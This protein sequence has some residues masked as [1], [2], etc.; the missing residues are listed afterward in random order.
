MVLLKGKRGKNV[1]NTSWVPGFVLSTSV[2]FLNFSSN[3]ITCR[4]FYARFAPEETQ[5]PSVWEP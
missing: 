5:A 3:E 1:L 4:R 2:F